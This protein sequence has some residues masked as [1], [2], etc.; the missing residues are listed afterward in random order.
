[1]DGIHDLGGK[2]GFGD[3]APKTAELPFPERW[4]CAVFTMVNGMLGDGTAQNLDHFRHAVERIDPISYLADGYYGRWLGAVETML[5]ENGTLSQAEITARAVAAGAGSEDRI[6]ARP[7]PGPPSK[8]DVSAAP[9]E[10]ADAR[11]TA[12]REVPQLARFVVGQR[13]LTQATGV[14]GHT[15]LPAYVRGVEGKIVDCHGGW[16]YPD[17]NA[18][19]QGEQPQHL[20]TVA[21]TSAVLWGTSGE[22]DLE[23]CVD[24][25]EPYLQEID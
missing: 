9:E 1:M 23:V 7:A 2:Q 25:F 5:V 19:G 24:L 18:H 13:V 20:Y 10:G 11:D 17:S 14:P 4:Q 12:Q 15:R 21:F 16:V 6:A 8:I 3:V 22:A